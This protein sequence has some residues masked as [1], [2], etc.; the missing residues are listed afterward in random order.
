VNVK[1]KYFRLIQIDLGWKND[2]VRVVLQENVGQTCSEVSAIDI[3]LA[4]FRQ[5]NFLATRAVDLEARGLQGVTKAHWENL[6]LVT[7]SARAETINPREILL[8]DLGNT[9]RRMYI[10]TVNQAVKVGCLLIK[11]QEVLVS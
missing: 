7:K 8:I 4:E 5:V 6:L 10:A 3:D 9:A 2:C 1:A 11:L